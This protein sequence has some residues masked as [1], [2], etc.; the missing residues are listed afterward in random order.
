[1]VRVSNSDQHEPDADDKI[2]EDREPLGPD[3]RDRDLL[4]GSWEQDYYAGRVSRRGW[5]GLG[6]GIAILFLLGLVLPTFLVLLK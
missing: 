2:G 4:D 3:E 6:V 1:M 5:T